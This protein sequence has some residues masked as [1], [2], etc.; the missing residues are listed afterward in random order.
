MVIGHELVDGLFP[1]GAFLGEQ[2]AAAAV[3]AAP[4]VQLGQLDA[5]APGA[6]DVVRKG[7]LVFCR[8]VF[9]LSHWYCASPRV[10][11]HRSRD[12]GS[13][14]LAPKA[15]STAWGECQ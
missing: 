6:V 14:R 11:F 3:F 2:V 15:L 9:R 10:T 8:A 12:L 1:A 5:A 7:K 13:L 4:F